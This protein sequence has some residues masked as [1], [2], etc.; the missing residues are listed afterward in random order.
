MAGFGDKEMATSENDLVITREFDAP[1]DL[2]W[3]VWT[4]PRHIEKWWG[5]RGFETTVTEMDL[6]VGG[7][8]RYVMAGAD[9][10]EYPVSGIITELDP[11]KLIVTT[12]EFDDGFDEIEAM[13]G[14]DLPKG[15]VASARFD[16]LGARTRLTLSISHATP[17]DR[18][19]HEAMGVVA[20]WGSSFDRM[21]D[22]LA[23]LGDLSGA[24]A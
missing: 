17:E 22:Y 16:D 11:P 2:V 21:D 5:P 13:K 19:K 24:P 14:I 7:K 10:T 15:I 1:R 20:G 9:G 18:A 8:W 6:R 3:R 4:E 23:T 12:D